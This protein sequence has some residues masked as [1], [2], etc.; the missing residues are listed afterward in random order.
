MDYDVYN[1]LKVGAS[2]VTS[3]SNQRSPNNSAWQQAFNIPSIIPVYSDKNTDATPDKYASP[4]QVGFTSNFNNPIATANYYNSKNET[5]QVLPTFYAE[6]GLIPNKLKFRTQ[7]SQ[8]FSLTNSRVF[9]PSYYV[10]SWQQSS[11]SSLTKQDKK[12]YN[13]ILDNTLTYQDSFGNHNITAMPTN[14]TGRWIYIT[15]IGY[16]ILS[17]AFIGS[18]S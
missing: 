12:Y 8:N 3:N 7:F 4:S 6:I 11:Q 13:Y 16:I 1:W 10:S 18:W 5:F 17:T 9:I 2:F 14:I 15:N